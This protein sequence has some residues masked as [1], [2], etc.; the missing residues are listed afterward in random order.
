MMVNNATRYFYACLLPLLSLLK[1][2]QIN[3][4]AGSIISSYSCGQINN[5]IIK[6]YDQQPCNNRATFMYMPHA[7]LGKY[8]SSGIIY[9]RKSIFTKVI[10][11]Y[12]RWS[13][14]QQ[15]KLTRLFMLFILP[16]LYILKLQQIN[17]DAGS[18]TSRYSCGQ[19]NNNIT[20]L[21]STYFYQ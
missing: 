18:R 1:L 16:F 9:T 4:D 5:K 19:I 11:P 6:I 14:N 20:K 13:T 8:S 17:P 15:N 21:R 2:Q 7:T 10:W 12:L 3:P